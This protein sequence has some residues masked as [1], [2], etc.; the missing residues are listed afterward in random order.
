[1]PAPAG[2]PFY[3]RLTRVIDDHAL[4][5][6]VEPQCAPFYAATRGSTEPDAWHLFPAAVD[7]VLRRDRFRARDRVADRRLAG[8]ARLPGPGPE[9]ST[10][11]KTRRL[12]DLE[13]HRAV[14]T[15]ILP[16]L[17]TA[18]LVKGK[19]IGIDATT[20]EVNAVLRSIVRRDSG[21]TYQRTF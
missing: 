11:S 15:W 14:L 1:V 20:L 17:A 8:A 12:I 6:F 9:H 7:R 18:D 5:D 10:I 4:D 13:P 21:E 3:Q 16:V 19:M 2:H